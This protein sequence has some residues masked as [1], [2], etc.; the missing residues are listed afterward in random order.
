MAIQQSLIGKQFG[1]LT[2]VAEGKHSRRKERMWI[3]KCDCGKT[4]SVRTASLLSGHT[5]SCG[6]LRSDDKLSDD[7]YSTNTSGYRNISKKI[8]GG[9]VYYRVAVTYKGKQHSTDVRRLDKALEAREELRRK[10]WPNYKE[11]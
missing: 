6:H 8:K 5:R 4:V 1:H 3:C 9:N 11:E 2:V 10:W 7:S